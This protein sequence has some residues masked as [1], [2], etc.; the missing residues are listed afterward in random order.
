MDCRK[1]NFNVLKNTINY[2]ICYGRNKKTLVEGISDSDWA[3]SKSRKSKPGYV[4]IV[5]EG[6]FSWK[7]KLQTVVSA[8]KTEADYIAQEFATRE[9]L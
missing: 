7:S 3:G 8:S 1:K 6:P 9:A 5:Y 2:I 4:F